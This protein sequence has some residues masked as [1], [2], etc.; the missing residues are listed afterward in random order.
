MHEHVQQAEV[1]V[2]I[3]ITI[4]NLTKGLPD[5]EFKVQLLLQL[6]F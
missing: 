4:Y 5:T 3:A 2:A 1:T 6:Q